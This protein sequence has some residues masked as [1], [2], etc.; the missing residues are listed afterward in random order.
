MSLLVTLS[1]GGGKGE[2][3]GIKIDVK[4]CR[5]NELANNFVMR[6][7]GGGGRGKRRLFG[8]HTRIILIHRPRG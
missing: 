7:L 3:W 6:G 5:H 1:S 4:A 8:G 2:W